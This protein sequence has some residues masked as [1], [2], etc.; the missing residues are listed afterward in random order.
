MGGRRLRDRQAKLLIDAGLQPMSEP[1]DTSSSVPEK[2]LAVDG[3]VLIDPR[4]LRVMTKAEGEVLLLAG[5]PETQGR[6]VAALVTARRLSASD[7][8]NVEQ[9]AHQVAAEGTGTRLF[10]QSA[11]PY[12]VSARRDVPV[13]IEMVTSSGDVADIEAHLLADAQRGKLDWP[14]ILIDRFFEDRLVRLL[15]RTP[16]TPNQI[17][18]ATLVLG[19]VGAAAFW[20]EWFWIGAI[21]AAIVEVLDGVDG[22]LARTRLQITPMGEWE[23]TADK[24]VEYALYV[25]LALGLIRSGAPAKT[26]TLGLVASGAMV[27]DVWIGG[28]AQRLLGRQLEDCGRFERLFRLVGGRRN[29]HVWMLIGFGLFG[30]WAQGLLAIAISAQLTAAVRFWRLY[31]RA[32]ER[33][34]T[35]FAAGATRATQHPAPTV[36]A[37]R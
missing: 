25:G 15:W 1:S 13:R 36:Q 16:I 37:G 24:I 29:T 14:S 21:L 17:S 34:L 11:E 8:P 35:L 3:S 10:A 27:V 28:L 31:L 4:L 22:K 30:A 2:F 19:L 23:H 26:L 32:R 20:R 33:G 6:C 5:T 18:A 9:L 7:A 12:V